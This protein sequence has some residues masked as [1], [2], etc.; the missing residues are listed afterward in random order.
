MRLETI[1]RTRPTRT[2]GLHRLFD[3]RTLDWLAD[4]EVDAAVCAP[5]V[6]HGLPTTTGWPALT[7]E[8]RRCCCA[9]CPVRPGRPPIRRRPAGGLLHPAPRQAGAP[10][11]DDGDTVTTLLRRCATAP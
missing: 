10:G 2:P 4:G 1:A 11:A 8:I 9:R 3:G 5:G 7:A 6:L